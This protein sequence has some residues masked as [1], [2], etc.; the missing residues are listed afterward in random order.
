MQEIR[1]KLMK[2]YKESEIEIKIEE[3][4]EFLVAYFEVDLDNWIEISTNIK[5]FEIITKI[6]GKEIKK[7]TFK[8]KEQYLFYFLNNLNKHYFLRNLAF[9]TNNLYEIK[10]VVNKV[11][12]NNSFIKK[13]VKT[14]C[15]EI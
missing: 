4:S 7:I 1:N 11:D 5:T 3:L 9:Y 2:F 6:N 13:K 10:A 15:F 12:R 14:Y 8:N